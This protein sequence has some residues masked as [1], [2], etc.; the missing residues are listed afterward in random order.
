MADTFSY[1]EKTS[2]LSGFDVLIIGSGIVGLSA[3]MHLKKKRPE[4]NIG[5]LESG[6]IPAGASTKNAGFAC[7]GSISE[8]LEELKTGTENEVLSLIEMRWRGLEKLRKNL[9]DEA[10]SFKNYGGFELFKETETE[11]SEHCINNIPYFNQLLKNIIG[12]PD[13][14]AVNNAKIA[15]FGLAG[16]NNIICN[17]YEAQIDTGK[18]MRAM[19][20]KVQGLGVLILNNCRVNKLE[21]DTSGQIL[22]TNQGIIRS[23]NVI[24]ATNAYGKELI[25]ELDIVPGRGQVLITEP[26]KDLKIMGTFHYNKGFTYFRNID[27][28]ILL[29]GFR[30]LDFQTE[31]TLKPGTTELIQN[32]LE[33]LLHNT[34]LPGRKIKIEQR[35][36]GVMGFG[37]ELKPIISGI[38][39]GL[40]CAVRCNGMGVAMGS[41]SGEQVAD[42]VQL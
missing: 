31:E 33:E 7:F 1:W 21:Q 41:L 13:I 23:N 9:G 8:L 3:G 4:L 36:S 18:M 42:L 39:P 34:I 28:R 22:H 15:E 12:K 2:F 35:W 6:F 24:V 38:S 25:P 27:D 19:I 10:L 11:A 37:K 32:S 20:S 40:Y 29:G 14:Y 17:K 26:V 30:D 16:I 5:I